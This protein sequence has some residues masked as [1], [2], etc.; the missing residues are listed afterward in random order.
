MH[1]HFPEPT[2]AELLDDPLVRL[3]MA[4]DG[5]KD[6]ALR[7]LIKTVRHARRTR[8]DDDVS[9]AELTH[10]SRQREAS[11]RDIILITGTQ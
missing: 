11:S 5:V 4:S 6:A 10:Q 8:R 9:H 2:L 1:V 7:G 3:V